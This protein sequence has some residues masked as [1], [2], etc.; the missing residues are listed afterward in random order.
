[1]IAPAVTVALVALAMTNCAVPPRSKVVV[2]GD[3]VGRAASVT[4][5]VAGPLG[6]VAVMVT[7]LE[8]GKVAG[9]VKRP[10]ELTVPAVV[11]QLV[12]PVDVNC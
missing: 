11:F 12:A 10:V 1:M 5:A 8:A 6:P 9:A 4:A 7:A 3:I 2:T